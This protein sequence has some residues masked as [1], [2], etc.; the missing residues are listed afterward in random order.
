MTIEQV[1]IGAAPGDNTGDGLRTAMTKVNNNFSN[2]SH[3]ASKSVGTATG[4]IPTADDL[5]VVGETNWAS[6]NLDIEGVLGLGVSAVF[7][8]V[9]GGSIFVSDIVVGADL[10]TTIVISTG[11]YVGAG[12]SP[13]GS[14]KATVSNVSNGDFQQMTKVSL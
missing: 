1:G 12:S 14:Y 2:S 5:G 8:N 3:A 7:K 9:S 6:G 11:V 10:E 4:E 13:T